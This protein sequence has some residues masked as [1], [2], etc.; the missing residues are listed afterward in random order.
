[1]AEK[2]GTSS[3]RGGGGDEPAKKRLKL[4][5][6]PIHI[7]FEFNNNGTGGLQF[8][9][10][11]FNPISKVRA[12]NKIACREFPNPHTGEAIAKLIVVHNRL[13]LCK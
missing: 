6:N 4:S 8:T 12:A 5:I 11:Y 13:L 2:P 3:K 10:H 9:I 1:M 7:D